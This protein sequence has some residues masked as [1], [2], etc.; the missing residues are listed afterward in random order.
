[1]LRFNLNKENTNKNHFY[2]QDDVGTEARLMC[3]LN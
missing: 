2:A 1:M 3:R